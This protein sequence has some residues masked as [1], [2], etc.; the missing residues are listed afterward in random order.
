MKGY[1]CSR[2]NLIELDKVGPEG[3]ELSIPI[4]EAVEDEHAWRSN[5]KMVLPKDVALTAGM[6]EKIFQLDDL[7]YK[8]YTGKKLVELLELIDFKGKINFKFELSFN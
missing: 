2:I 8:E 6:P 1:D 3:L 7:H 5:L 4:A